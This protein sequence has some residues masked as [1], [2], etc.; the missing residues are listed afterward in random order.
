[1][2]QDSSDRFVPKD[3]LVCSFGIINKKEKISTRDS[4][5]NLS[6][7]SST[8][9]TCLNLEQS[10][11]DSVNIP[12]LNPSK[13]HSAVTGRKTCADTKPSSSRSTSILPLP[14]AHLKAPSYS[15]PPLDT[16]SAR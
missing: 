14:W 3:L 6:A 4:L 15:L 7:R 11:A 9:A 12:D 16:L 13:P 1:M 5:R 10:N 8:Y 2:D